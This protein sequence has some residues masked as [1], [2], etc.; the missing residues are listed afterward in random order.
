MGTGKR[1][2]DW[3]KMQVTVAAV[4]PPGYA[5]SGAFAEVAESIH[6]GLV[7]LGHESK[8]VT[9]HAFPNDR[10]AIVLGANLLPWCVNLAIPPGSVLY[11]LEQ[12]QRGSGWFS[13]AALD[14]LRKYPVWDYSRRNIA[15]LAKEGIKARLVPIGY[16]PE[17]TR[18]PQLP[19]KE[20]DI[21][22]LFVGSMND[23]RKS[24][25]SRLEQRGLRVT[26]SFGVY[27]AHRDRIVSR[28]KI[29]LN[30]HFYEAKVLEI[31]RVSYMMANRQFVLSEPGADTTEDAQVSGGVVFAEYGRLVEECERWLAAP[32]ER[33]KVAET[34][35]RI[36][37]ARPSAIYLAEAMQ[38]EW[39]KA[40]I[41]P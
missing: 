23:R 1:F 22:V 5:H 31:V 10:P 37:A 24:V 39:A 41:S 29:I 35:Y 14:V 11:N 40:S 15:A 6:H 25:I 26:H 16:V 12:V 38:E 7:L 32:E 19:E 17:L 30:I 20:R 34:G 18:I 13:D 33:F 8:I 9:G 2:L 27:G 36:M 3:L 4:S 21:D 28:A